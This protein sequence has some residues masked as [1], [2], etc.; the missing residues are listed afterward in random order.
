M[1]LH[2]RNVTADMMPHSAQALYAK[3]ML[4]DVQHDQPLANRKIYIV[5]RVNTHWE[6]ISWIYNVENDIVE[7]QV[8]HQG[9]VG[10]CEE[11]CRQDYRDADSKRLAVV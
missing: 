3:Q 7:S 5:C 2:I 6:S 8:I 10:D 9:S 1:G 4:L 11:A